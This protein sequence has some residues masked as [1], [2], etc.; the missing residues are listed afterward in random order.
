MNQVAVA[1][2]EPQAQPDL[3]GARAALEACL[4]VECHWQTECE[5][6]TEVLT[7]LETQ[8]RAILDDVRGDRPNRARKLAEIRVSAELLRADLAQLESQHDLT[9][10]QQ[11][12]KNTVGVY[13]AALQARL[14]AR[15]AQALERF[16]NSIDLGVLA[17]IRARMQH[18]NNSDILV[19][20]LPELIDQDSSVQSLARTRPFYG[21]WPDP[22]SELS[23]GAIKPE[24]LPARLTQISRELL[25][26]IRALENMEKE[27]EES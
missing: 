27:Q 23:R 18:R 7:S 22:I 6:L 25:K 15:R 21:A 8:E 13:N 17:A 4:G 10:W 26:S 2:P 9:S 12:L 14:D 20:E 24:E 3:A 1:Q 19:D 16:E 11:I 5:S